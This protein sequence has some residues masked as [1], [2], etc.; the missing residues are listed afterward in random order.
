[1][2]QEVPADGVVDTW[3]AITIM[4][5]DIFRKVASVNKVKTRELIPRDWTYNQKVFSLDRCINLDLSFGGK[6]IKT[7]F[8]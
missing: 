5:S 2:V 8:M 6:M 1:M 4:G 3:A 7:V